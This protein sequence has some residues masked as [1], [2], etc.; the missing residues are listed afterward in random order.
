MLKA[1]SARQ[2]FNPGNPSIL[3]ILDFWPVPFFSLFLL[4]P[5]ESLQNKQ[6]FE[7]VSEHG[8]KI[9]RARR[10]QQHA[11]FWKMLNQVYVL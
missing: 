1:F 10:V 5:C 9:C 7:M 11:G 4:I 6:A 8:K 2:F 3:Q